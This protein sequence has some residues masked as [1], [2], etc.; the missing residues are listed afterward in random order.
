MVECFCQCHKSVHLENICIHTHC[1][2]LFHCKKKNTRKMCISHIGPRPNCV[3]NDD[4]YH[5]QCHIFVCNR[6]FNCHR[7][8]SKCAVAHIYPGTK[9]IEP[10]LSYTCDTLIWCEMHFN[11][12]NMHFSLFCLCFNSFVAVFIL[13]S[14]F[15]STYNVD[16]VFRGISFPFVENHHN[17]ILNRFF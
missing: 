10:H 8:Y 4:G 16:A 11:V 2:S 9:R 12:Y 1:V 13:S 5:C 7:G 14:C 17:S 3:K 6:L 15:A